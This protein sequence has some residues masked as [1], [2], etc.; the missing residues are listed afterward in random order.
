MTS[1]SILESIEE[2]RKELLD[3]S[4][5][6]PLLNYR[7]LRARGVEMV[8]E[9]SA[10]VFKTLVSDGRPMS[11]LPGRP[12]QGVQ[13]EWMDEDGFNAGQPEDMSKSNIRTNQSDRRL[14]TA[15]TS[16]NLQKRLLNTYRLANSTIEETGVNTL[17]MALG[18]LRWY[19]ADQS[20]EEHKAPLILVP[21]QV[22][23]EGVRENFR[24]SYTG[25]DIG[26]NLSLIEKVRADFGLV[27]PGQDDMDRVAEGTIGVGDYISL[28]E[29]GIRRSRLQRWHVDR[30]SIV[31]GFFSYN[32]LQ[33][34][35]DLDNDVWPGGAGIAENPIIDA[36]FGDGFREP[37][38]AIPQDGHL[39]THLNPRDIYHVVDADSS[40]SLAIHDANSGRNLVIQGPPGTGK[41]QTITNIIAEAIARGKRV[42]FVAE[43]MAALEVVKRRLDNI[44]LGQA[45]LELHSHKTNRRE[46][47]NDLDRTL[48]SADR[49]SSNHA[50]SLNEV[51]RIRDQ[52][53]AYDNAVNVPVGKSGVTPSDAFGELLANYGDEKSNPIDW[54]RTKDIGEW[55][56]AEFLRKREVVEDLR[57]RLQRTGVPRQ[58]PFWG[59][60]LR[61]LLPAAQVELREKIEAAGRALESL[62]DSSSS[63][64]DVIPLNIPSN[65]TEAI[66]LLDEA[67]LVLDAPDVRGLNLVARQWQSHPEQIRELLAKGIQWQQIHSEHDGWLLPQAW[68]TDVEGLRDVLNTMGRSFWG[69]WFSSTYG[70]ACRQ[71]DDVVKGKLPR[72]VDKK[73]ALVD[74]I[75][76]EQ[77]LRTDLGNTP[78]GKYTDIAVIFGCHWS[79]AYTHWDTVAPSIL[80]WL[81]HVTQASHGLVR[82]MQM[83]ADRGYSFEGDEIDE[84]QRSLDAYLVCIRELESALELHNQSRFGDPDGLTSLPFSE[85][86]HVLEQWIDKLAEIQDIIGFSNAVDVA[87]REGLS[88]AVSVA[89]QSLEAATSLTTWFD[90][91]WYESIVGTAFV[92][93]PA[94]RDFDGAVH[95]SRIERF[96]AVDKQSLDSNCLRVTA[97]HLK[98]VSRVN[99]LP[100]RLPRLR[101]DEGEDSENAQIR[102]RLEQLRVLQREIQKKSRHKP[103]RRLIIEAGGVIQDLKP[104]FMMSPL[105][106][107]NYLEPGTVEFDLVVFDE[108]SQ[109]RPVDALGALLRGEKAIVVGDSRQLPPTSFFDRVAQSG[110]D[111]DDEVDSVTAD[112]ESILRLF[113]AKG[114]PSRELRWHY[115]SRHESLIAV[116]NREFYEN[117]LVVF[118]SPDVGRV[119]SGLRF[120]HLTDAVFDRGRSATNRREAEVVARAVM[121]QASRNPEL[122]LGVAAFSIRQA[123]AI[124]DQLELLRRQDNSG[125][126][127]FAAH[128]EEPFFVKNLE[129]VQ[130]DER[131]V[132][133]ISVGYGRDANGQVSMNFGPL[134]GEGGERRLNVLITRAKRQCHVFTNLRS[135]DIDLNRTQSIGVRALKAFLAYAETG[136]MP[137]DLPYESTF[138]VDSPF[139]RAVAKRLRER[140]YEVHDEVATVGKFIDIGIVD[141]DKPGRYL[142]GIEC[143]GAS[144]HSARSARDRDRLR[145][146]VLTDLGWK[147]HRIWST[148]W[149]RNP[150][151]ELERAVEAIE[152]AK[153]HSH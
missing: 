146:Q 124:Q 48:R 90:R 7:P 88:T 151:R 95:E 51:A 107:A 118:P 22:H 137:E 37:A 79:G 86:R 53:N 55:S 57:I 12:S 25:E 101:P 52:L 148:D 132:I 29:Q 26:A 63:L 65:V 94:L 18:I 67:R 58:H 10:Q 17:F 98:G 14:Q 62:A 42:L 84:V 110:D 59:S 64:A 117:N 92:E 100:D 5:R 24:V 45:C 133:F 150:E 102:R 116:S 50:S 153:S 23:R 131:D 35:R 119:S 61:V 69:R 47:L 46:I 39:D 128:P 54:T 108:A 76:L 11:F 112:I 141:P 4:L 113:S 41:S 152:R 44:G 139:Q 81:D 20:Q 75:T 106:I 122:S 80:W 27:L 9:S 136:V 120:H 15:E 96:Q 56:G 71:L 68:D 87:L 125:E 147:L 126:E 49:I 16:E 93:R 77:R 143:D 123:Q 70:R 38:P 103:I 2:S 32:K 134:N 115:R 83:I 109:V 105:S 130:G 28:V 3:L 104:V 31:L 66:A 85:Q 6:N 127:F 43:K 33:M 40:Q 142:I 145:E 114:A 140:G 89:E 91:A 34:F 144:Y 13:A 82:V 19:E 149:F 111:T 73:I 30:D 8:G 72:N 99:D 1:K 129:N 121:E 138:A 97:G 74:A 36:L 135:D 78:S 21:V 60:G